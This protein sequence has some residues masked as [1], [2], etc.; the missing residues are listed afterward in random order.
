MAFSTAASLLA[1]RYISTS[2]RRSRVIATTSRSYGSTNP[3]SIT[4]SEVSNLFGVWNDALATLDSSKVVA[5][6]SN[7]AV[8]LPTVSDTP[9]A[10]PEAIEAYF[11]DEF[12]PKKP[13]GTILKSW[14]KIG[15][16]AQWAQD[17]GV[18]EFE[19]GAT[20]ETVKARYTFVYALE[21]GEWKIVHHHSSAMPEGMLEAIHKL[22]EVQNI[23]SRD[24]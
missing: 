14:I 5:C 10:D 8:L 1:R 16:C 19:L 21:D 15:D 2:V 22:T 9:R 12:L 7:D 11:R 24:Y 6:Y 4:E 3:T 13:H 18:Y 20:G 17:N 23:M